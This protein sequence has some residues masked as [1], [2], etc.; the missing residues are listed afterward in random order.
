MRVFPTNFI[1][2]LNLDLVRFL[3]DHCGKMGCSKFGNFIPFGEVCEQ[4]Q[5]DGSKLLEVEGETERIV[6]E[7]RKG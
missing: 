1:T 2:I 4:V 7:H 6:D 3:K 5:L